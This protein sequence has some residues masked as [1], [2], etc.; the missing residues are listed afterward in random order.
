M[1]TVIHIEWSKVYRQEENRV[2]QLVNEVFICLINY[3]VILFTQMVGSKAAH[4]GLGWSAVA[5][6][7]LALVLN[8]GYLIYFQI[9]Q[10]ITM[11]KQKLVR[12]QREKE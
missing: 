5:T 2:W 11:Y 9:Q 6:L 3:H 1:I 10:A 7:T 4:T 8:L 12:Q